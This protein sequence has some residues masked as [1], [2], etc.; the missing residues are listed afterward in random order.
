MKKILLLTVIVTVIFGVL[1]CSQSN[2]EENIVASS[3]DDIHSNMEE[4]PVTLNE[5]G[6]YIS[7]YASISKDEW[8]S[9]DTTNTR[10]S[11]A[12]EFLTEID[13]YVDE[14][15]L[16]LGREE[17]L[18]EML[19]QENEEKQRIVLK[20]SAEKISYAYG[21][22]TNE[23]DEFSKPIVSHSEDE[24]EGGWLMFTHELTHIISPYT[25]SRTLS[26]GLA[27]YMQ[28]KV[29]L[30]NNQLKYKGDLKELVEIS[31]DEGYEDLYDYLGNPENGKNEIYTSDWSERVFYYAL[32]SS[33]ADYIVTNYGFEKFMELY[34]SKCDEESYINIFG[35][36]REELIRDFKDS[37][38]PS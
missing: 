5:Q 2:I 23:S 28:D 3:D 18:N 35:I 27:C 9:V 31:F 13:Y 30:N 20:F 33:F 10:Y 8:E 38:N 16:E 11:T 22:G 14:I 12:E 1:G 29:S 25:V 15:V 21:G 34:V 36:N 37:I 32:S 24:F 26:E 7:K 19:S 4:K 6:I 17:W